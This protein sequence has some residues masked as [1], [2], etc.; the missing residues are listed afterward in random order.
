MIA[1]ASRVN[2][3]RYEI[4]THGVHLDQGVRVAAS[5][6]SIAE[7]PTS[8]AVKGGGLDRAGFAVPSRVFRK[9]WSG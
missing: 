5:P 2:A 8:K 4:V 9:I 3:R 6:K 1:K 7:F